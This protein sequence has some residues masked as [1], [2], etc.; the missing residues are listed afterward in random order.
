LL[1]IIQQITAVNI[2]EPDR[3]ILNNTTLAVPPLTP[4][5]RLHL[6]G[7]VI[8]LWQKI[9]EEQGVE[10]LPPPYWAFAWPGGQAVARFILDHP[11]TVRGKSVLDFGAG[12]GLIAIAA[13]MVGA[14]TSAAEIDRLA[15]AAIA[16][17][18][19]ANSVD[20]AIRCADVIG[21]DGWEVLL[22]GDMCYER[23][24]AERLVAWLTEQTRRGVQVVIGDPGRTYFPPSGM[25]KLAS[26][27]IPTSLDLEDREK[28][29]TGVYRF[30]R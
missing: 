12:S 20:I 18:A 21:Q 2:T 6:G 1:R 30:M 19:E 7:D 22:V 27:D 8:P 25:E 14:R 16:L 28:R 23:P 4:E 11:D 24:L 10:G 17:N 15:A 3:F 5:I 26:Y 29:V 9:E 13:A